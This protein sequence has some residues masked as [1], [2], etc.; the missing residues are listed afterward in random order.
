MIGTLKVDQ[1]WK[2]QLA[3]QKDNNINLIKLIGTYYTN[4]KPLNCLSQHII[5]L[6]FKKNSIESHTNDF[7]GEK[8]LGGNTKYYILYISLN[9]MGMQI[10]RYCVHF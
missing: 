1:L 8:P 10:S 5:K 9:F 2:L 4:T 6:I 7:W 3:T